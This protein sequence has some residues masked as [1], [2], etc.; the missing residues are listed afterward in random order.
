MKILWFPR[1][2][3]DIDKLHITT[4]REMC[5]ELEKL[6][7]EVKL[8]VVGRD[9]K[10]VLDR[11]YLRLPVIKMRFLRV[12]SF[13][14]G[15]WFKFIVHY[16]KFRPDAVILDISSYLFSLPFVL[17][18]RRKRV[19]LVDNRTPVHN[20]G[21]NK[22]TRLNRLAK[23]YTKLCYSYSKRML[24]GMT[25]ITGHYKRQVVEEYGFDGG[26]IAVW[27]SGVDPE[28]F[29]LEKYRDAEKPVPFKDKFVLMQLSEL[30]YN[31]GIF[32]TVEA[33]R[34]VDNDEIALVF[35]GDIAGRSGAREDLL[36]LIERL[37][38]EKN[39]HLLPAVP[40][41]EVPRYLSYADC[42]V[43]AYPQ[44]EY[45]N[46]NN[47]IKL[48]EFL[49]MGKVTICTDMWTFRDVLGDRPCGVFIKDNR[50]ETIAGAINLCYEN[51]E[52][53]ETWGKTGRETIQERFTW[54][55][56]ATKLLGFIEEL[57]AKRNL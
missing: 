34:I 27:E 3:F 9:E 26:N 23:F 57:R 32:E 38:L 17:W 33:L 21:S 25:V 47:P 55:Q 10:N 46:N 5:R 31:R 41:W 24:D 54:H 22:P 48:L 11:P 39:V 8:A 13:W 40:H 42:A 7:A 49:A 4:W 28:K 30:S 52:K 37:G 12:F 15:G 20:T 50:P 45:W 53:L 14:T 6:G 2:Q 1:L 29:T 18:P 43:L 51:R 16:L 44:I 19:F 35:L 36:R 56:Q